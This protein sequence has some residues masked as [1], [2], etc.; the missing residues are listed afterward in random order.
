MSKIEGGCTLIQSQHKAVN[1]TQHQYAFAR[2]PAVLRDMASDDRE[3]K[4]LSG[5]SQDSDKWFNA[6]ITQIIET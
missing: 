4:I 6:D 5:M 2:V 1:G 3:I